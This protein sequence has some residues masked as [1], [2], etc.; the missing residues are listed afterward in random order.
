MKKIKSLS[1]FQKAILVMVIIMVSVFAVV[2]PLTI[3]KTGIEYKNSIFVPSQEDNATV[4]RGKFH[5]ERAQILVGED[6]SVVFQCG[7]SSYGPYFVTVDPTALPEDP[8]LNMV[9]VIAGMT[10]T[11]FC[12]DELLT[13]AQIA[14]IIWMLQTV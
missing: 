12:P 4:Y 7:E 5:G 14:K 11:T 8:A 6:N 10:E 9:G 13:R 2:Y 3:S 1:L